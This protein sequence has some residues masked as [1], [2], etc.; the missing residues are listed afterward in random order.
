MNEQDSRTSENK[1]QFSNGY[2]EI[3]G[4]DLF[5]AVDGYCLAMPLAKWMELGWNAG[6][7][8]QVRTDREAVQDAVIHDLQQRFERSQKQCD[9]LREIA[10]M[11]SRKLR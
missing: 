10:L 5:I 1:L 7:R 8:T 2:A 9:D 11:V 4:T 6:E 3:R